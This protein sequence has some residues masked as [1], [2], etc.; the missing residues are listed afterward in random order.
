MFYTLG[1]LSSPFRFK[2]KTGRSYQPKGRNKHVIPFFTRR[3]M[4]KKK[5][6]Y[7]CEGDAKTFFCMK[8][9]PPFQGVASDFQEGGKFC[10]TNFMRNL[11]LNFLILH[12]IH[13]KQGIS[14]AL[15]SSGGGADMSLPP[16]RYASAPFIC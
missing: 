7:I 10:L 2:I 15:K 6:V 4:L 8:W 3:E 13:K 16:L 12:T 1:K 14:K 5:V 9:V 11:L